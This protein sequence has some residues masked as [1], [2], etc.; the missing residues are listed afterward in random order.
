M[1]RLIDISI[2]VNFGKG[3]DTP[4]FTIDTGD[5]ASFSTVCRAIDRQIPVS[6]R[7]IYSR[8]GIAEPDKDDK[9]DVFIRPA[10]QM[11]YGIGGISAYDFADDGQSKKVRA[12]KI[13]TRN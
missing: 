10:Q 5:Y 12:V 9:D 7:S 4:T 2:E 6:R 13:L 1:Q 3:V 8:Y 11:Q